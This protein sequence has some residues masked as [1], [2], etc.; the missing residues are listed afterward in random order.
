MIEAYLTGLC[1]SA[2]FLLLY[3]NIIFRGEKLIKYYFL[4]V[5]A[6]ILIAILVTIN[7][8]EA[9]A[10]WMVMEVVFILFYFQYHRKDYSIYENEKQLQKDN[11]E[12]LEN[13]GDG[14]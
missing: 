9:A 12:E 11:I 10:S 14:V 3:K 1:T 5:Q 2:L 13:I 8:F 4:G 7:H 6:V